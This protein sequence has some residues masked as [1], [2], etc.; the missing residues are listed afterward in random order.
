[1]AGESGNRIIPDGI[2]EESNAGPIRK[3]KALN[4][5]GWQLFHYKAE[6]LFRKKGGKS[7]RRS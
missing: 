4:G 6:D 1:M 7:G 3:E 2:R 5:A